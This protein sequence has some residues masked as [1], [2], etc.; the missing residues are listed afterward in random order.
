MSGEQD[1]QWPI[2]RFAMQMLRRRYYEAQNGHCGICGNRMK[3]SFTTNKLTFDHVWPKAWSA[4]HPEG[5]FL[6][7][8]LLTHERC[9]TGK[10]DGLPS[11]EQVELLHSVNRSIGFHAGETAF[12]DAPAA[13]ERAA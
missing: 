5:K 8:L 7:N 2:H 11:P 12:W 6:G 4:A 13:R 10:A 9:N 3:R 1:C